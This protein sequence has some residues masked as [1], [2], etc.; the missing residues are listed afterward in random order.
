MIKITPE[1]AAQVRQS[2]EHSNAQNLSLRIAVRKDEDG[3]FVYGMG[4][5]DEGTDDVH[6]ES[7]GIKVLISNSSKELI[8]GA[9]LDFVEISPGERQF[10]FVNP[11]DPA[12]A[13]SPPTEGQA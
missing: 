6:F 8:T 10:I 2:S 7:E 1:A 11:N 5:D 3:T 13:A 9:T 12:H 4:F